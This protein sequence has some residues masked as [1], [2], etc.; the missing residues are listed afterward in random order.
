MSE[1]E[2][3]LWETSARHL[4][5]RCF[6]QKMLT[7]FIADLLGYSEQA[8]QNSHCWGCFSIQAGFGTTICTV[9]LTGSAFL[10][11]HKREKASRQFHTL[12]NKENDKNSVNELC[13]T[14]AC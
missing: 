6:S 2:E 4:C 7:H 11:R 5:F 8:F 1:E 13:A 3:V 10:G 9:I 12:L 14:H